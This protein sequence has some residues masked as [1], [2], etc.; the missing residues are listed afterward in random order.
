MLDLIAVLREGECR[1]D[2]ATAA[3]ASTSARQGER[4]TAH[5]RG[6]R[7]S[8]RGGLI[9]NFSWLSAS[10]T[11]LV[12]SM[13]HAHHARTT[14]RARKR[15][16]ISRVS[17]SRGFRKARLAWGEVFRSGRTK[18][19]LVFCIAERSSVFRRF[20]F[21]KRGGTLRNTV[22]CRFRTCDL[23]KRS[24]KR[25]QQSLGSGAPSVDQHRFVYSRKT[26]MAQEHTTR[27]TYGW[28]I[29]FVRS[30]VVLLWGIFSER[31]TLGSPM[32]TS[33]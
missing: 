23:P 9:F 30:T 6:D 5:D 28:Y 22:D 1:R 15:A 7:E 10:S 21:F 13:Q 19:F 33:L 4:S 16:C 32:W 11:S 17:G 20:L 26:P 12:R 2:N 8:A 31:F 3:E 18:F 27:C 24:P 25:G 29:A 14:K